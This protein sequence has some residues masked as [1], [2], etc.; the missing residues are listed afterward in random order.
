[1]SFHPLLLRI[2]NVFSVSRVSNLSPADPISHFLTH[3]NHF[4]PQNNR[5]K[6]A[7][8]LP[9][10]NKKISGRLETSVFAT[11]DLSESQ[12]WNLGRAYLRKT[13]IYGCANL[14]VGV[15]EKIKLQVV[16][17]NSPRRHGNILGW[18]P[19]KDAQKDLALDLARHSGLRI[20]P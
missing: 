19:E 4:S 15:A 1:M 2:W 20:L 9:R 7:P 14:Q 10:A 8:F 12:I 16:I 18:P 13:R 11:R 3:K 17:D 6:P 5:V